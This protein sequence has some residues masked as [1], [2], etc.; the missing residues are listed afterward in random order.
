MAADEDKN[1]RLKVAKNLNTDSNVLKKLAIDNHHK[2]RE[3]IA[4]NPNTPPIV[5]KKIAKDESWW[6]RRNVA[7]NTN[8][9]VLVLEKLAEDED[10]RVRESVAENANTPVLVLEK[11]AEDE[12]SRVRESAKEINKLQMSKQYIGKR[13]PT[14]YYIHVSQLSSLSNEEQATIIKG[15]DRAGLKTDSE[16]NVLK[17][18]NDLSSLSFLN[19][20]KFFDEGFPELESSWHV[21]FKLDKCTFRTYSN[22]FNPPILHRKELL[23][24]ENH[25][26]RECFTNLT[27]EAENLGLFKDVSRIGFRNQWEKL[28]NNEG[29]YIEGHQ[30]VPL[31]NKDKSGIEQSGTYNEDSDES[32]IQRHR[33]AMV[34][35]GFS[36]PIQSLMR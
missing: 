8:T 21:D 27:K 29:Y 7:K 36:A 28:V 17:L 35:Y 16:F 30:F 20:P 4:E 14:A 34:R 26:Q 23:L 11:L 12:D 9:P 18:S 33:T 6:A 5:L 15:L 13:T 31:L 32:G 2:V 22:S 25:P 19:Y 10:S 1:V 24:S 3:S